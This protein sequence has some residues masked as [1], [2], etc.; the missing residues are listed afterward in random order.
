MKKVATSAHSSVS[1]VLF[2]EMSLDFDLWYA[3]Y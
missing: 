2:S 1:Q 3:V